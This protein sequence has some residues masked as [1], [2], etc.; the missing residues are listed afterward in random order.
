MNEQEHFKFT[1]GVV[2]YPI[3]FVLAIW[4]VFWF[5]VRFGFNFTKFGIYPLELKGLRGM[6]FLKSEPF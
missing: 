5:E 6:V 3:A 1:T 4:F 2:A